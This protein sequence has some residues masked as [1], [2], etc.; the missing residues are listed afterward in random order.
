ME[1][2]SMCTIAYVNEG[3]HMPQHV[4]RLEHNFHVSPSSYC[5][6]SGPTANAFIHQ[7]I[8]LA[9]SYYFYPK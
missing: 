5:G 9:L 4:W 7:P 3:M 8:S 2:L 1:C 6:F